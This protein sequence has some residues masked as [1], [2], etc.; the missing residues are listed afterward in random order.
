MGYELTRNLP[1]TTKEIE[2]PHHRDASAHHCGQESRG[3]ADPA[4][5]PRHGR[6]AA[7][8]HNRRARMGHVGLYRDHETKT[9][10][11]VFR[12]AARA[13]GPDLHPGRSDAGKPVIPPWPPWISLNKRGVSDENIRMMHLVAVPEGVKVLT[14]RHP[15]I[16]IYVAALDSHLNENAYIV[17]WPGRC[18]RPPFSAPSRR[19]S[20]CVSRAAI[21]AP[22]WL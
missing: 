6:R 22:A 17:S 20:T 2:T 16:P 11:R 14:E 1:M 13:R 18:G 9:A 19:S 12:E 7:R 15:T 4:R 8:A 10:D 5:R 3:R 21:A